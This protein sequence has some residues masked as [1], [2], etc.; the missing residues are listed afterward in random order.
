MNICRSGSNTHEKKK[1][2]GLVAFRDTRMA[3]AAF[4]CFKGKG[5][6]SEQVKGVAELVP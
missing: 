6:T 5:G 1:I 3:L 4:V 2:W